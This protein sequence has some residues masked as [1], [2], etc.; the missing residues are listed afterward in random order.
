[1]VL[2]VEVHACLIVALWV[3]G[4]SATSGWCSTS[5]SS[6]QLKPRRSSFGMRA[7]RCPDAIVHQAR[8]PLTDQLRCCCAKREKTSPRTHTHFRL[9][10][11][12]LLLGEGEFRAWPASLCLD[13]PPTAAANSQRPAPNA[14]AAC[15]VCLRVLPNTDQPRR[16]KVEFE[17][18]CCDTPVA[19]F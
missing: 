2:T 7:A 15:V 4:S 9:V 1:M 12:S 19:V 17:L 13:S 11:R 6:K 10:V 16:R 3:A 14:I 5:S 8:L 18:S